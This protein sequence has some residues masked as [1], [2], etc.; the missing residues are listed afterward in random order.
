MTT[1][2]NP[3]T[4]K[5]IVNAQLISGTV[6]RFVPDVVVVVGLDEVSPGGN[7]V[8]VWIKVR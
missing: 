8:T 5:L 7:P 3:P 2:E 4:T 6:D 1:L